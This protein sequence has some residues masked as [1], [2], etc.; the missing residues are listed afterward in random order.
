MSS[1]CAYK[2]QIRIF[3]SAEWGY[4]DVYFSSYTI[5]SRGCI[6]FINNNFEQKVKKAKTDKNGNFIILNMEIQGKELTLVNLYGP[7]E[8][9]PQF[10]E[11][12]LKKV[13]EAD[14]NVIMCGDLNLVLDLDK[15]CSTYLHI[16][17]SK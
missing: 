9:N 16:N 14:E 1:R 12:I 7:N 5:M 2:Q 15:D 3:Y 4:T 13:A 17:N 8:D 10:Y 11:T 6:I